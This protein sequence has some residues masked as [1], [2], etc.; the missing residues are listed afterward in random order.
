MPLTARPWLRSRL[1]T[2]VIGGLAAG[3]AYPAGYLL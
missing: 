2:F 3:V 1:E